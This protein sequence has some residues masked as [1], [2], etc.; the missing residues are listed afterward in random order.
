M[1]VEAITDAD[2]QLQSDNENNDDDEVSSNE[3]Y[4]SYNENSEDDDF[5]DDDCIIQN[6]PTV[7]LSNII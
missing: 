6:K 4:E 1:N 3:S 5:C 7:I 2:D